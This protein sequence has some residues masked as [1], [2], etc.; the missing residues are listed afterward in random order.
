[1]SSSFNTDFTF[2]YYKC[3]EVKSPAKFGAAAGWDFFIPDD[4]TIFDF[5]NNIRCIYQRIC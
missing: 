4:L 2:E 5:A 1:M 3:R